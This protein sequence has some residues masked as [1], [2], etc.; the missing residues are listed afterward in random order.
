MNK[1]LTFKKIC[2]VFNEHIRIKFK[3]Y[4]KK[5]INNY[6]GSCEKFFSFSLT[7][8]QSKENPLKKSF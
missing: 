6:Q 3:Y 5:L 4:K 7:F 2:S 1:T 8:F